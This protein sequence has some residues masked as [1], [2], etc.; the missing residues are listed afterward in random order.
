MTGLMP[1]EERFGPVAE[2]ITLT[3]STR[4][5]AVATRSEALQIVAWRR[6]LN[7]LQPR[8]RA[9]SGLTVISLVGQGR[10]NMALSGGI[11]VQELVPSAD[12]GRDVVWFADIIS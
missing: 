2:A 11:A 1:P 12:H 6:R 3:A 9:A 10:P 4:R 8:R 5:P 7:P